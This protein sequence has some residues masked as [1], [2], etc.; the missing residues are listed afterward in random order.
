ME[1][2]AVVAGQHRAQAQRYETNARDRQTSNVAFL[3]AVEVVEVAL[4]LLLRPVVEEGRPPQIMISAAT[5][6]PSLLDLKVSEPTS[7]MTLL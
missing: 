3:A 2:V 5:A 4:R 7:T 6:R 1:T